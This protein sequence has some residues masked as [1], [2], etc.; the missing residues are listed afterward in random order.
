MT[1]RENINII[2]ETKDWKEKGANTITKLD[3][4]QQHDK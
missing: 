2:K 1:K 4:T 3:P